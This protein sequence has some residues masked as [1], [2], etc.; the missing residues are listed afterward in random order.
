MSIK[1]ALA[2]RLDAL[3]HTISPTWANLREQSLSPPK[4]LYK[5]RQ[6]VL[7]E[8]ASIGVTIYL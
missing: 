4:K 6:E 8:Y 1:C 7:Q 3:S 5:H 2:T